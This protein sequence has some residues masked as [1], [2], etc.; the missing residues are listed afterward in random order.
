M[1]RKLILM[2]VLLAITL[3]AQ[4]QYFTS[5]RVL[6]QY[7]N[8]ISGA[9][10]LGKGT[11]KSVTT[12]IDGS[13][14]LETFAPIKK[15]E[16]SYMGKRTKTQSV[17]KREDYTIVTLR[18]HSWWTEKPDRYHWFVNAESAF[19]GY[20]QKCVPLGIM[21]GCAKQFGFYVRG[22]FSGIPSTEGEIKKRGSSLLTGKRKDGYIA[23][24]AGGMVRLGIPL[25][26]YAGAGYHKRKI[27]YEHGN[28]RWYEK[29]GYENI[30]IDG[31]FLFNL[32]GHIMINAGITGFDRCSC[33]FGIGYKF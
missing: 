18:E 28:K 4:A 27:A 32:P 7:G 1:K 20:Q 23:V 25:Y 8:P 24:T 30:A 2:S 31:G 14:S 5:G 22:V 21:V 11:S 29:I 12:A 16:V 19:V 9:I 17:N 26:F 6:D 15:V 3:C 33:H 10:V 13:F